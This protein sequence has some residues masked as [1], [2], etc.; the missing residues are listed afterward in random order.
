[1]TGGEGPL[2]LSRTLLDAARA[3]DD[4][5]G[6]LPRLRDVDPGALVDDDA[7]LAFW[8]NVYNAR[9]KSAVR[10]RGLRGNLLAH[11]GFFRAVGWDVGGRAVT[12]HGMEHG[13]LRGN[14]PAPWTF[15]RPLG[16]ADPRLRWAVR[17]PDARVHFALNCGAVS[18][19]PVRSY[20]A[21]RI[22][23][24]L[25]VATRA[26]LDTEVRIEGDTLVLPYL[27]RLYRGDFPDV[28]AFAADHVDDARAA[29]IRAHPDAPIR[30]GAYRWEIGE[31]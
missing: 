3:G 22:H 2:A 16:R 24:Q 25:D 20:A 28:R 7:R 9:V 30:W 5:S 10:E 11:R 6:L 12:L 4:L 19:P 13:L 14:R 31:P 18:C 21:G 27:C 26:Y 29:W 1:M 23:E 8:I 15:W 17:R